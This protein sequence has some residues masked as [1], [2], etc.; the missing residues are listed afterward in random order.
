MLSLKD[1]LTVVYV[2]VAD[3]LEK[4]PA[5]DKWRKSNHAHPQFTDAE[6]MTIALMQ[7]YF[8]TP[9]LK[10]TFLLVKANDRGAFP[11]CCSY[12]QWIARLNR[13]IP[14]LGG[15]IQD[16]SQQADTGL[17]F[18]FLDSDPIPVCHPIRHARVRL[19]RE[20]GAYFGKSSKGWFF[21]F[22]LH[23]VV[24]TE[25]LIVNAILTPG[26]WHDREAATALV[27]ILATGSVCLGDRIYHHAPLQDDIWES[28]GVV[29]LTRAEAGSEQQA[30]L[31]SIRCRV[32]TTFS[33][34]WARF[35]SRLFSRSWA[36]LWASLLL[37]ILDHSLVTADLI[38]AFSTQD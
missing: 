2:I 8:R 24:N 15:M 14:Q 34:L 28:D 13:L 19:L 4:H 20:D 27:Q 11:K 38:P 31:C 5:L 36:G 22:K 25:G 35:S 16:I 26:N 29:L 6:V 3:F 23:V 30:L 37:K 21:G 33:Q 9:T 12:Q 7:H 10:Q 17:P 32:E 18:Y 1:Q